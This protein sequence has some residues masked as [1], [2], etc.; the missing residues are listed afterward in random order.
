[1]ALCMKTGCKF[2]YAFCKLISRVFF[3]QIFVM[4]K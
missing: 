2:A 1:M 4:A 3:F